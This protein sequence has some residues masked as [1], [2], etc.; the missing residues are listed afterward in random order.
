MNHDRDFNKEPIESTDI[1]LA[2]EASAGT[3]KTTA[4]IGRILHLVLTRG[5]GGGPLPL[6]HVCAI[7]F[8]EKA[9]GEMKIRL[10]QEL[11]ARMGEG[12]ETKGLIREAMQE[13]DSA[14]IST[15]H[16]LAVS[17][18][19]E[20]PFEA[21]LD[22]HFTTLDEV[23]GELFFGEAWEAWLKAR[24]DR[25]HPVLEESLRGGM[26]LD[27]LR[28]LADTLRR[29]F[30]M[31]RRL[32]LRPPRSDR[33]IAVHMQQ[34]AAE[35]RKLASMAT[36]PSD[37]LAI[38]L[39]EALAWLAGPDDR[40]PPCGKPRNL[41]AARNWTGGAE[42]TRQGR[43]WVRQ[44]LEL[45]GERL[46]LPQMRLLDSVVRWLA[47][48]FLQHWQER[49][50]LRSLV[51]FDDHLWLARDLLRTSRAARR[52]FQDR[53]RAVLVD[54]FQD[55]DPVQLEMLLLLTCTDLEETDPGGMK[56]AAGRLFLVGDPKQS[57]YRFRGADIETYMHAVQADRMQHLGLRRVELTAN[58]RS[59]PSILRF[60]DHL[61]EQVMGPAP[62]SPY[63][64]GYLPFGTAG[65][66]A[67]EPHPPSVHLLGD[68][69]EE[70][71]IAGSGPDFAE[72][73]ARRIARLIGR[74]LNSGG[75]EV[76]ERGCSDA[77]EENR[78]RAPRW[79][80]IAVL[81]PVLTHADGL[82][83]ALREAGIP[84]V[85]EGGKFY[86]ARSEVSSAI[87]ILR[88]V[89][90]PN[91][92]VLLY[93]SLR[94]IFFGLSDEDLLRMRVQRQPLDYR[95]SV[96]DGSPLHYPYETLRGLH[97]RRHDRT[98]AETFEVLLQQTRA[99]EVLA[100]RD[101]QSLANLGKLGRTLRALQRGR[102][103]SETV[104]L[105]AAMHEE[106]AAESE[107]RLME[108]QGDAVRVLSMHRSKGLDFPVVIVAGLG[109]V[110]RHRSGQVLFDGHVRKAFAV[111]ASTRHGTVFTPDWHDLTQDEERKDQAELVRLLYVALTRARDHLILSTH[112]RGT[113]ASETGRWIAK[114]QGTRFEPL[115]AE[116]SSELV[117]QMG[118][119]RFIDAAALD[120]API[121][122]SASAS[123]Q[124]IDWK[125]RVEQESAELKRLVTGTPFAAVTRA[126]GQ[127]ESDERAVR[128]DGAI[129]AARGRAMRLGLAFHEAMEN[130]ELNSPG[131]LRRCAGAAAVAHGLDP[132]SARTLEQMMQACLACPLMDRVRAAIAAGRRVLREV[133]FV[134]P[135]PREGQTT[136]VEEGKIDLLFEEDDGWVLVDYKTDRAPLLDDGARAGLREKYGAQIRSYVEA[137]S[138][139]GLR[140]KA[141]CLL[142]ASTG[143]SIEVIW[144]FG[145]RRRHLE[146]PN[147]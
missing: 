88:A 16:A 69:G 90:N 48:D 121:P 111:R 143:D 131:Q 59:V 49:K 18:L 116:L 134:R 37:K 63:Q 135:W 81:L 11:E 98:A 66:R 77:P 62:E 64:P 124:V 42:T 83:D 146:T 96:P 82:E 97:L 58:W 101:F 108:E 119:A 21:G 78:R 117:E 70:G 38:L 85:L 12:G 139:L 141:A 13:L 94:S 20:R 84:Y 137:M 71:E 74:I 44:L 65:G 41:G 100:A 147:R 9:A 73:E 54:E 115:A 125:T 61:F 106:G 39:R 129:G 1:S 136:G 80:D 76:E 52:E 60:V 67:G 45:A 32:D 114:F 144:N 72:R 109:F 15:F 7:T 43:E 50:R 31:V 29:H 107:S 2:V 27:D 23:Q 110:K 40:Y 79:G 22:P 6:R 51:D 19:K 25:R 86:Y 102:P 30:W 3:G 56:P 132:A 122:R 89:A 75:W 35:G 14:A 127:P 33:E 8:T 95:C 87:N 103:F 28:D 34:L 36:D 105:I 17:L 142:L 68:R 57:I 104:A 112:H 126:A 99:R 130:L 55:T 26:R 10:R 120:T 91:D 53:F 128:E 123:G 145:D 46:Q 24:I 4:L 5:P 133:P 92:P 118:L 47:D 93:A 140:V 138:D 113:L